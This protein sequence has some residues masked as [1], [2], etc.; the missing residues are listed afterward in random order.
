M[1]DIF[2]ILQ[3]GN[4]LGA[5]AKEEQAKDS[6]RLSW[7]ALATSIDFAE[8]SSETRAFIHYLSGDIEVVSIRKTSLYNHI[9]HPGI[10]LLI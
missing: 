7:S 2:V 1:N 9:E 4:I 3:Y 10:F 6:I 8:Y 5:F